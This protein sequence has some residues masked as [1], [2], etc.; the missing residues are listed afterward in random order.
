MNDTEYSIST[1]LTVAV[2]NE[3]ENNEAFEVYDVYNACKYRGA[4][5]NSTYLGSWK[6]ETG[7]VV[8]LTQEK[9]IRR[10]NL[11]GLELRM[12]ALVWN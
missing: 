4:S 5:L 7:L 3:V 6:Y 2:D 12:I 1:D 10:Q 9:F 8:N 11:G